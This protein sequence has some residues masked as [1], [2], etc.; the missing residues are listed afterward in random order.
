MQKILRLR[1]GS[2]FARYTHLVLAFFASGVMRVLIDISAGLPFS[3]SGALQFFSNAGCW[4][5]FR[6]RRSDRLAEALYP[7]QSWDGLA[8]L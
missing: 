4:H 6:G 7:Q 1:R 2:T 5:C 3:R 8:G